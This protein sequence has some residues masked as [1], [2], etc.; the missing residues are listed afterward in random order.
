MDAQ[1]LIT[2]FNT[3][4]ENDPVLLENS[5]VRVKLQSELSQIESQI[6]VAQTEAS[7][8]AS[9]NVV[10]IDALIALRVAKQA[11]IDALEA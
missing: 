4:F 2:I 1:Q 9:A 3:V 8:E 7:A 10:A 5:L 11:E 6:T